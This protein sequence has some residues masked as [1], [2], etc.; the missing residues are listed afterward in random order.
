MLLKSCVCVCVCVCLCVSVCKNYKLKPFQEML[1][2]TLLRGYVWHEEKQE[3]PTGNLEKET[4]SHSSVLTWGIPR[5]E[6]PAGLQSMGSQRVS[7]TR[8]LNNDNHQQEKASV[9]CLCPISLSPILIL[10][11]MISRWN[12][13]KMCTFPI[14]SPS[15]SQHTHAHTHAHAWT[16]THT[17]TSLDT[18]KHRFIMHLFCHLCKTPLRFPQSDDKCS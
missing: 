8:W 3:A 15:L 4:S 13:M 16:H 10:L 6:E 5:T 7:M 11:I 14:A 18:H 9:L 1:L 17:H 12:Q 2:E